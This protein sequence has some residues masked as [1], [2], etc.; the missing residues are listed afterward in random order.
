M[1]YFIQIYPLLFTCAF[2][3]GQ[4][5]GTLQFRVQ[6]A[7][8]GGGEATHSNLLT[9]YI[10]ILV[11][12]LYIY[13]YMFQK[14]VITA[15]FFKHN[16]RET[17]SFRSWKCDLHQENINELLEVGLRHLETTLS[18]AEDPCIRDI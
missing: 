18:E 4:P 2:N 10:L 11:F 8:E 13:I 9:I 5:P 14:K 1:F 6:V 7:S 17:S 3:A 16:G 12:D 15:V